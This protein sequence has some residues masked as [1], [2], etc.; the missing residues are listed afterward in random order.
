MRFPPKKIEPDV[1]LYEG[2]YP[3]WPGICATDNNI[4]VAV[5]KDGTGHNF[6]V[7]D[8]LI[9]VRSTDGGRTWSAPITT[10]G[11]FGQGTERKTSC[12]VRL[13]ASMCRCAAN[14]RLG[15]RFIWPENGQRS[16]YTF[17]DDS[18]PSRAPNDHK[19]VFRRTERMSTF[20]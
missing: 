20:T 16:L 12:I 9:A 15:H 1:A 19:P 17:S 11:H 4:L 3:T 6:T 5:T 2:Q 14:S 7:K 13:G 18:A 8:H 10:C